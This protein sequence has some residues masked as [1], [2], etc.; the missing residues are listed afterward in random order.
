ADFQA[1]LREAAALEDFL[2]RARLYGQE[3]LFLIGA[4]ILSGTVSAAQAGVT[5]ARLAD[6]LIRALHRAVERSFAETHG[7]IRGGETAVLAMG[8]L[9]GREMTATSDLDLII[10]YDFDEEHPESDGQ[11]PLY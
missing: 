2:D 3:H 4:R 11:R 10:V 7:R 5:F 6:V 8:K 9:G 1:S